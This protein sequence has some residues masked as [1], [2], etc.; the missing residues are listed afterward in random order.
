VH[1]STSKSA[2]RIKDRYQKLLKEKGL[3]VTI[4][5]VKKWAEEAVKQSP[6]SRTA[7]AAERCIR[8]I[9]APAYVFVDDGSQVKLRELIALVWLA[10]QDDTL[11]IG[12]LS[13]A[14][15]QYQLALYEIQRGYNLS[16][17]GFDTGGNDKPICTAGTFNKF[18]EKLVGLHPDAEQLV[19]TT[20]GATL[21]LLAVVK[22]E[23]FA[24]LSSHPECIEKVK[25]KGLT[26]IWEAIEEPVTKRM[27][28][29]YE[30][31][32]E[33]ID[34]PNFIQLVENGIW[35]DVDVSHLNPKTSIRDA[36]PAQSF[37]PDSP[38]KAGAAQI[39][40]TDIFGLIAP[41]VNL[42]PEVQIE[43]EDF[44]LDMMQ[45]AEI[46]DVEDLWK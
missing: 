8:R 41:E 22:E 32:F 2:R 25:E 12:T 46:V 36:R 42:E 24:Y 45:F 17:T 10:I 40:P 39:S 31:L 4:N 30:S 21:K 13:D 35:V 27:F 44:G 20:A 11:R 29:E 34:S 37:E 19:L 28:S 14:K 38:I 15:R 3:T 5:E 7:G 23:T 16:D 1:K 26:A 43:T 33:R 9:T 6:N 18:I